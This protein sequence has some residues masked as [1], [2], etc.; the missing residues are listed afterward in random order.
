M[1]KTISAFAGILAMALS[2]AVFG[3]CSNEAGENDASNA[4]LLLAAA[5]NSSSNLKYLNI[6]NAKNLY[7][8]GGSSVS[9]SAANGI[10]AAASNSPSKRKI[11]KITESGYKEEVKYLDAN[12]NEISIRQNEPVAIENVNDQYVYVGFGYDT[13]NIKSSYL[14]RKTDGAVFD[15]S[16]A[17]HPRISDTG[18]FKNN[19]VLKTDKKN[20]LYFMYH[21]YKDS[22]E[23]IKII[24]VNLGGIDSLEAAD[25]SPSTD[26]VSSFDVDWNGNIIYAGSIPDNSNYASIFYRVKKANGGITNLSNINAY[27]IG[28]DGNIY[29]SSSNESE[30]KSPQPEWD[31]DTGTSLYSGEYGYPIKKI[32][33]DENFNMSDEILGYF[34]VSNSSYPYD[35]YLSSYCSYKIEIKNKIIIINSSP[36]ICEVYNQAGAPRLVSLNGLTIKSVAA[37]A[38]TENF[39]Y[40]AAKDSSNNM[41]LIKVNPETDA[42]TNL[43]P[44]NEYDVFA[45]T[46]SEAD[47]ITFNALRMSDGK[48]IIGKVGIN[49]GAVSV[50]DEE[51]DTQILC[52]ER[53]N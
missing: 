10:S 21:F 16:K 43:L 30:R 20:N 52:L 13:L 48:K 7:I 38:S 39:Y 37:V 29:Y 49:G 25:A 46:A 4:L 53:I 47:G 32:C 2:L 33:I 45:F 44:Q 31:P 40:L 9:S 24:K 12:K 17:G 14:V 28:L 15:I 8:T 6:T 27:W 50:I 51:S 1:K 11:F 34:K 18:V 42:W 5:S 41:F 22:R 35:I 26:N 3:A 36:S 19:K 23:K